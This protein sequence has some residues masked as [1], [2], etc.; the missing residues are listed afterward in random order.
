ELELTEGAGR[1]FREAIHLEDPQERPGRGAGKARLGDEPDARA[2]E[3]IAIGGA[4]VAEQLDGPGK[5]EAC[6][7]GPPVVE[8]H[9]VTRLDLAAQCRG[10][11]LPVLLRGQ[12]SG[13]G[14]VE[15][16][17][18]ERHAHQNPG[19]EPPGQPA[20]AHQE[21]VSRIL[22]SLLSRQKVQKIESPV[23]KEGVQGGYMEQRGSRQW[24]SSQR[25][26]SCWSALRPMTLSSSSKSLTPCVEITAR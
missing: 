13:K 22:F 24:C 11:G 7:S 1:S 5:V 4:R 26:P 15:V 23:T 9:D 8:H 10:E 19:L 6:A 18:P 16:Q 2:R 14:E 25:W 20:Q 21:F 3:Q 12:A 17:R